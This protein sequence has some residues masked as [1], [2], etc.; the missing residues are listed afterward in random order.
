[1]AS[2]VKGTAW[3][4]AVEIAV[5]SPA[6]NAVAASIVRRSCAVSMR[7]PPKGLSSEAVISKGNVWKTFSGSVPRSTAGSWIALSWSAV[8]SWPGTSMKKPGRN[9][10]SG[11]KL[12]MARTSS[13]SWANAVMPVSV[14]VPIS[15]RTT[16]W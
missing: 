16:G 6:A 8:V 10:L 7:S 3:P 11:T 12:H 4:S 13:A 15:R 5:T 9:V 14:L 2:T 1:M